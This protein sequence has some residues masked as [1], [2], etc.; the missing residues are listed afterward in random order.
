MMFNCMMSKGKRKADNAVI[1]LLG[2]KYAQ[3]GARFGAVMGFSFSSV[4]DMITSVC[5]GRADWVR[6]CLRIGA[7]PN[8]MGSGSS[9]ALMEAAQRPNDGVFGMLFGLCDPLARGCGDM[10]AV[11]RAV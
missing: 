4:D 3:A 6:L 1:N 2:C 10:D 7:D 8:G 11:S 5:C 9:T